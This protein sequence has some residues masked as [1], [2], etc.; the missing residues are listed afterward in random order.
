MSGAQVA[1]D[2]TSSSGSRGPYSP[3]KRLPCRRAWAPISRREALNAMRV[4]AIRRYRI[5]NRFWL[6]RWNLL[7]A[8]K[9]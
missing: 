3:P 1:R 8:E 2:G 9:L 6:K 4:I 7:Y 5:T